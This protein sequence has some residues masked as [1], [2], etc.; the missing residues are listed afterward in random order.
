V[1]EISSLAGSGRLTWVKRDFAPEDLEGAFLVI[2]ATDDPEANRRAGAEAGRRGALVNVVDQPGLCD[3]FVPAVVRRGRLQVA[4]STGG[5]SPALAHRLRRRF[6]AELGPEYADYVEI[7]SD[8]R[9]RLKAR[10]D[11]AGAR[12][13]AFERLFAS[14]LLDQIKDGA[15]IDIDGLVSKHAG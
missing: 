15:K 11:D 5:A 13:R 12:R 8:F 14:D 3:F 4:V 9:A 10:V 7:V 1:A 2:A 6:E